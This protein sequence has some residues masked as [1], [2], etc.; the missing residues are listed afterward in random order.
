MIFYYLFLNHE[1]MIPTDG[2]GQFLDELLLKE[3]FYL[4]GENS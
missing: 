3:N 1:V 2:D 4:K